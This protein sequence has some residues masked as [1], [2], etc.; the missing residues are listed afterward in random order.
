MIKPLQISTA[1]AHTVLTPAQKK[2]N[3]TLK[4]IAVQQT[5]L[6]DWQT[7]LSTAQNIAIHKIEPLKQVMREHQA[8]MITALDN[9]YKTEKLNYNQ[10]DKISSLIMAMCAELIEMAGCDELKPVYNQYSASDYD[11]EVAEDKAFEAQL[12]QDIFA[13]QYGMTLDADDELDL[14]DPDRVAARLHEKCAARAREAEAQ[15]NSRKKTAK[16]LAQE[17]REQ[18]EFAGISKS[19]QTVYRQLATAL[20]PDREPD[21][22]ERERKTALMQQVNVAYS[23]KDLL[24]LL[25]LQLSIA[26][27]NQDNINTITEDKLKHYNKVLSKQLSE[28]QEEVMTLEMQARQVL[29]LDGYALISPKKITQLLKQDI[30]GL[31]NEIARIQYDIRAFRDV[32]YLK[33]WLK[34]YQPS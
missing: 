29:N 25:A 3:A 14:T 6:A 8:A 34:G 19:I 17:A 7:E 31:Q 30:Q 27:I 16:Q 18:E 24:Q 22:V 21:P 1:Q 4:K 28:L 13:A 33:N 26:Q 15:L 11:A 2:F 20:H 5:L 32:K 12:L 9:A 23:K 10:Q